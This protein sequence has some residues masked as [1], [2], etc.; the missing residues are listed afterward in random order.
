MSA[1]SSCASFEQDLSLSIIA[2]IPFSPSWSSTTGIPPPPT[3]I[4]TRPV[5]H[6][7]AF[8]EHIGDVVYRVEYGVVSR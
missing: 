6:A 8:I 2:S 5:S 4:T 3:A 7:R 1:F